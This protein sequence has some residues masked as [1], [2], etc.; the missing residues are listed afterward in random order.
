MSDVWVLEGIHYGSGETMKKEIHKR[1]AVPAG[2][3][4]VRLN[5]GEMNQYTFHEETGLVT[6]GMKRET[7]G[8]GRILSILPGGPMWGDTATNIYTIEIELT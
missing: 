2:G 3:Y 6:K 8:R 5:V 1:F 4:P 7:V